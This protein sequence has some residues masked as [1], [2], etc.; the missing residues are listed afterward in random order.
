MPKPEKTPIVSKILALI[1]FVFAIPLIAAISLSVYIFLG[2][3][4]FFTQMRVGYLGKTFKIIKFRSMSNS[5]DQNGQLKSDQIRLG[6]FGRF[7]RSFSLDEIPTLINIIKGDMVFVGPRPLLV[8]Y[9]KK[10]TPEQM[11]RHNVLPGITGM[12]QVNG[13]NAASWKQRFE[14]D[15]HYVNN[16]NMLL[17]IKIIFLTVKIV[18]N[19]QGISHEGSATMPVFDE[20]K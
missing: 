12:A 4:I 5:V 8:E 2:R 7:L 9:L 18:L 17:D 15:L 20:D 1:I 16:R 10:Y 13:R 3:P 11:E 14:L 19:R 6:S